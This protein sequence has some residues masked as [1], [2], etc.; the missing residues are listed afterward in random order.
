MVLTRCAPAQASG[1]TASSGHERGRT[2]MRSKPGS[3]GAMAGPPALVRVGPCGDREAGEFALDVKRLVARGR[4][5]LC[6]HSRPWA[7]GVA[8]A[9]RSEMRALLETPLVSLVSRS[10]C[11]RSDPRCLL[12]AVRSDG[13]ADAGL[14]FQGH[15]PL[16]STARGDVRFMPLPRWAVRLTLCGV[17]Q[18]RL[19]D[20]RCTIRETALTAKGGRWSPVLGRSPFKTVV[21]QAMLVAIA[22]ASGSHLHGAAD[23]SR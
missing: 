4:L 8:G 13:R 11:A 16:R 14:P 12:S 2:V 17:P 9:V 23:G 5:V 18:R 20:K 3:G 19:Q 10:P 21:F 1:Q 22:S 15:R 7:G 6:A